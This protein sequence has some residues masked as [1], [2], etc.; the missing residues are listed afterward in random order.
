MEIT[1]ELIK[2]NDTINTYIR[3]ADENLLAMGFTEHSFAHVTKVAETAG[4]ILQELGYDSHTIELAKIAGY[5]HDIGN[6]VNRIDHAQSG[7]VM[8]FRILDKIGASDKDI[9]VIVAAIGNHDESTAFPVNPVAAALI[10]ADKSDVRQ[11]RVRKRADI[12]SD[13][14]DRVNYGVKKQNFYIDKAEKKIIL[15]LEIDTCISEVMEYFE[16]FIGRMKLWKKAAEEL[17]L[18]CKLIINHQEMA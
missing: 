12:S 18:H 7:A 9:A 14:H 17:G 4:Y 6:V 10:L 3:Q 13:I 8:S 16:I 5:M 11:S 2:K 1:Y 15:S